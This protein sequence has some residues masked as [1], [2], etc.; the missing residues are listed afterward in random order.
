M[1]TRNV[2]L[3]LGAGVSRPYDFPLGQDLFDEVVVDRSTKLPRVIA[4]IGFTE[5]D[6]RQFQSELRNSLLRSVDAFLEYRMS[7]LRSVKQ[8]WRFF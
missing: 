4:E 7:S 6:L 5:E 8:L 1:I 2:V 3:I